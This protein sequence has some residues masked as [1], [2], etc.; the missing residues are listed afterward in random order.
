VLIVFA[1][2][3][4]MLCW[5]GNATIEDGRIFIHIPGESV[6]TSSMGDP[7]IAYDRMYYTTIGG[8]IASLLILVAI[9]LVFINGLI[10]AWRIRTRLW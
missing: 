7:I 8:A 9:A 4:A 2:A 6:T 1:T 3:V 5:W 10:F